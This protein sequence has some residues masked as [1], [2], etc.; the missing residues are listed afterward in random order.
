MRGAFEEKMEI[1]ISFIVPMHNAALTI[2]R[3]VG[4]ITSDADNA[5]IPYEVLI[6][7]N[8][9]TDQSYEIAKGLSCIHEEIRIL[10]SEKGVS[11]ARNV[12]IR[13][14][15]GKK[16]IF[17]DADDMWIA[18]SVTVI[19]RQISRHDVDLMAYSY[20]KDCGGVIH[21]YDVLN[22]AI[23]GDTLDKC[24]AWMISRPTMRM[25]V[26]AK[27]F[28]GDVIAAN[29]L[30][31]DENL[32]YSEDSEFMLRY[33]QVCKHIL[34]SD[35]PI[36]R[37][38]SDILSAMRT[39]DSERL[40]QYM[41]SLQTSRKYMERSPEMIQQAFWEYVLIHLNVIC[42]HDIYDKSIQDSFGKKVK[43]MKQ[44]MQEKV[45]EEALGKVPLKACMKLQLLPEAFMKCH[46]FF[47]GGIACYVRAYM[48]HK[49]YRKQIARNSVSHGKVM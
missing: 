34:V 15:A 8:G 42:V 5:Q 11:A 3:C 27:V 1:L 18:G 35:I 21:D 48:N 7:E 12:G 41:K 19:C 46:L 16:L 17:V 22:Q 28:D 10:K 23:T 32:R 33:L 6:I 25:Q 38:C 49:N 20:R 4:S 24:R 40:E 44:I 29:G 31:F 30:L 39:Y 9:S 45:F 26:W 2:E 43:K 36:Y 14:A 47:G 37:Y 13:T